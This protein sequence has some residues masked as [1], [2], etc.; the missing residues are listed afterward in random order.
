MSFKPLS[1]PVHTGTLP[2]LIAPQTV[3]PIPIRL[4]YHSVAGSSA[5]SRVRL[6]AGFQLF[7]KTFYSVDS[8]LL[9]LIHHL[10]LHD[11]PES[12]Y[13]AVP[14]DFLDRTLSQ[15]KNLQHL[16]LSPGFLISYRHISAVKTFHA[17][18][19]TL[20]LAGVQAFSPITLP[21]FL[22]LFPNLRRLDLSGTSGV[23]PTLFDSLP[24]LQS[25]TSL[26]LR[27]QP[28][29]IT[30]STILQLAKDLGSNLADLDLS[31]A[32]KS[33]TDASILALEEF[34]QAKPP[35]Y[36]S[37]AQPVDIGPGPRALGIAYTSI[38]IASI[39]RLLR[40]DMIHLVALDVAGVP[41]VP[42]SSV[43]FWE[44]LRQGGSLRT[45][46][47]LRVDF[48]LFAANAGFNITPLP[49]LLTEFTLHNVPSIES[50]PPRVTRTLTMLLTDLKGG[51]QSSQMRVLNLEMAPKEDEQMLGMYAIE[52][53]DTGDE[54]DV[55]EEIKRW[56]RKLASDRV[57][58]GQIRVMRDVVGIREYAQE[59]TSGVGEVL[60]RW[61][62]DGLSSF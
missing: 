22:S 56:K 14:P 61:D 57:W 40:S 5:N 11:I 21:E 20:S 16:D 8:P 32:G 29:K 38:P 45:L 23:S 35:E 13:A 48:A 17:Q 4:Y 9:I 30:D 52:E 3:S 54:I 15:C 36:S 6:T 53:V 41:N 10:S 24:T 12:V 34:T 59:F 44:S 46:E 7:L 42:N 1:G 49:P 58:D 47:K 50:S 37:Q 26:R 62:F 33:I 60:P 31:F 25:L 39:S 28:Y 55:V 27:H 51:E 19:T 2:P 43:E 18:L